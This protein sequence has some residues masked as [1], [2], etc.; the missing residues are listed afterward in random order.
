MMEIQKVSPSDKD[1]RLLIQQLNAAL[2][3]ITG[4]DGT[5]SFNDSDVM[6]PE[7][8]FFVGYLENEPICCGSFR[9]LSENTAEMKRVYSRRNHVGAAHQ[10]V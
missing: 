8:G 6:E 9:R 4:N 7:S 10:M 1:A 5:G 3:E 2:Y